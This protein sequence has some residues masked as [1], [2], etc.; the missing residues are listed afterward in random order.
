MK[1]IIAFFTAS[2]KRNIVLKNILGH[3]LKQLCETRWIE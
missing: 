1:E 2:S 3:Q